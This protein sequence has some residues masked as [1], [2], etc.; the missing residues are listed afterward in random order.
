MDKTHILETHLQG[1]YKNLLDSD[2]PELA[3]PQLALD[4]ILYYKHMLGRLEPSP[5]VAKCQ[6]STTASLPCKLQSLGGY[7][8]C[9]PQAPGAHTVQM[10]IQ[11]EISIHIK[12]NL[13]FVWVRTIN[14]AVCQ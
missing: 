5:P 7:D 8:S 12:I 1:V 4:N 14:P 2:T 9:P 6:G 11:V 10:Y 13:M 3:E